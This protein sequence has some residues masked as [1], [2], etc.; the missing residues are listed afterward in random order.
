MNIFTDASL[1][2]RQNVAGVGVVFV[3]PSLPEM[4]VC[5]N[6]YCSASNIETA[7]L[8]AV[9]MGLRLANQQ[10][11]GEIHVALDSITALRKIKHVFNSMGSVRVQGISNPLEKK[12][13]LML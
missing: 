4:V 12:I 13:F 3:S 6:S 2:N 8:F 10:H 7:E 1:N 5:H 9:A 11:E